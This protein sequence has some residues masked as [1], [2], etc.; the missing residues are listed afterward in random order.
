MWRWANWDHDE[1]GMLHHPLNHVGYNRRGIYDEQL[2]PPG[3]T[4]E[5]VVGLDGTVIVRDE[6]AGSHPSSAT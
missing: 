1:V 4:V 3:Q 2:E 5:I 6:G